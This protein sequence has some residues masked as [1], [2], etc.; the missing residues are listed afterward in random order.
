MAKRAT[1]LCAFQGCQKPVRSSGGLLCSGHAEQR[2]LGKTL[3]PLRAKAKVRESRKCGY[4]E[5]VFV[6]RS[7]GLCW[8]HLEQQSKGQDLRTLKKRLATNSSSFRDSEGRKLCANCGEWKDLLE[9]TEQGSTSD[10]YSRMCRLCV[11]QRRWLRTFNLTTEQF[12]HLLEVQGFACAI[13]ERP[14]HALDRSLAVDHDHTCCP[15]TARSCGKCV[16]GL[17]CS[18]CN[19]GLGSFKDS[20]HLL[21][22]A[23]SYLERYELL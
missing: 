8:G 9:F 13:C 10:G 12:E 2:R 7:R 19:V 6:A 17:L 23:V 16:R 11:R 4:P 21:R 1:D 20:L 18:P 14:I 5:C 3:R 15:E 22:N